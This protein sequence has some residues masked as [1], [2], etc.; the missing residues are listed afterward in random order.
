LSEG[1]KA[2][3]HIDGAIVNG[4]PILV[5]HGRPHILF[6]MRLGNDYG[7]REDTILPAKI[8]G[9]LPELAALVA[10]MFL[11]IR[12]A[13]ESGCRCPVFIHKMLSVQSGFATPKVASPL[14]FLV[15]LV[16]SIFGCGQQL[17]AI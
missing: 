12:C 9:E 4:S 2:R 7:S 15:S 14:L 6:D 11:R 16:L 1:M 5:S 10:R 17:T 13:A 3:V 8:V